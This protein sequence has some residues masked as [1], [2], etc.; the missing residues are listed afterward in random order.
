M[1][2]IKLHMNNLSE[3]HRNDDDDRKR[4]IFPSTKSTISAYV[5]FKI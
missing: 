5:P 2:M 1:P 3:I 4:P